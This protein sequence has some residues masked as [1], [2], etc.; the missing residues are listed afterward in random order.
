[1]WRRCI[2]EGQAGRLERGGLIS[3]WVNVMSSS[4]IIAMGSQYLDP[5]EL[6]FARNQREAG[7]EHLEWEERI[8]PLRPISYDVVL[9]SGL[10][11]AILALCLFA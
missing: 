9:A 11:F 2:R 3:R 6:R 8:R 5:N 1:M 7:I 10:I 4:P